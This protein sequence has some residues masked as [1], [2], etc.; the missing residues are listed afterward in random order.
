MGNY[1]NIRS[2]DVWVVFVVKLRTIASSSF[3]LCTKLLT[4]AVILGGM[5]VALVA[6]LLVLPVLYALVHGKRAA[7]GAAA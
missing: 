4:E 5:P 7:V 6:T 2:V 1:V 3:N